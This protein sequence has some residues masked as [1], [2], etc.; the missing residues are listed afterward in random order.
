M[1]VELHKNDYVK[2]I[3]Y[4]MDIPFNMLMAQSV[5]LN[6]VDGNVYVDDYD[7]PKSFYIVHR[8]GMTY[9]C[10]DSNN[11]SFI[12]GLSDYFT[13]KLYTRKRDEWLQAYPRDW[14]NLLNH[15]VNEG[16][17]TLHDRLNF[18]FDLDAFY[19]IY[20]QI[21][22]PQYEII[23]TPV[24]M[25]FN[26]TGSVVPK[27]YWKTPEQFIE[28]AKAYTVIID[29]KPASTAFCSARHDDM[30][31]IGIETMKEYQGKG[32]AYFACA[33]LIEYCLK[34]KLVPVWSCRLGNVGSVKLAEKLGFVEVLRMPYYHIPF[35]NR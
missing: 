12:T 1:F 27:D 24:D 32:L 6:H 5:I 19:N 34:N 22:K 9:L 2:L 23:S 35:N 13:S 11:Q 14:D 21:E 3:D 33:K 16:V 10:G 18:K 28:A 4:I 31:E 25:L 8:Y 7:N 20:Q 17:V 26:I 30:F 15:F 29:D